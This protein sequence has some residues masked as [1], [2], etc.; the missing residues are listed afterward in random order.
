MD[1]RY[2]SRIRPI[3]AALLPWGEL[4]FPSAPAGTA[5]EERDTSSDGGGAGGGRESPDGG[6]VIEKARLVWMGRQ[7]RKLL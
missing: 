4:Q 1:G 7:E 5:T 2:I 3:A 6:V